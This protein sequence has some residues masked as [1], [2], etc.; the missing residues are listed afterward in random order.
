MIDS[1]CHLADGKFADDLDAVLTRAHDTGVE[2][3]VTIADNIEEAK[4]CI[5]LAEKYDQLFCTIGV[6]PHEASTWNEQSAAWL[7]E[8]AYRNRVVAIGEIG[9]DYHYMNSSKEDQI[10]AFREQI[11]IAQEAGLPIVVH[12]RDSITD[13]LPIIEE[14][15]PTKMVLHCCT[16]EWKNVSSLIERGYLLSFTGIATYPK[17]DVIRETI[18]QCPLEQM[19]IETDAPYL[20]PEG[21]RGQRCEPA[22]VRSVLECIA[23]V[24]GV[25]VEEIDRITTMTTQEFFSTP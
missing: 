2:Q 18:K 25:S 12:N 16:E 9:L 14:L 24:K 10:R 15:Q 23:A 17:S 22:F 7:R 4:K 20:A 3:M 21:K 19:M 11:V 5:E 1:H 8:H 6:H 13:L